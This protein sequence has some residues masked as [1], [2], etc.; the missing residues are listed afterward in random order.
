MVYIMG[1]VI[2][3]IGIGVVGGYGCVNDI[4]D[5]YGRRIVWTMESGFL[6]KRRRCAVHKDA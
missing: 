1:M 2:V 4:E 5:T 3:G 6:S